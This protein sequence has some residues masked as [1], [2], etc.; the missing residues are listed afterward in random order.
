[1]CMRKQMKADVHVASMIE[2]LPSYQ[3]YLPANIQLDNA[4]KVQNMPLNEVR[5]SQNE[6]LNDKQQPDII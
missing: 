4:T 3:D 6:G 1:M 5:G 2:G